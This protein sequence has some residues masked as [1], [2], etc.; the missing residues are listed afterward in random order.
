MDD[1]KYLPPAEAREFA[2]RLLADAERGLLAAH[3]QA[4]AAAA[5]LAESQAQHAALVAQFGPLAEATAEE[6]SSDA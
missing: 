6:P 5:N 3:A 4:A 2:R 1:L